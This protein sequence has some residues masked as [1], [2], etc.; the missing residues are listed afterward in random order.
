RRGG[1]FSFGGAADIVV[2]AGIGALGAAAG[3]WLRRPGGRLPPEIKAGA[4]RTR[5]SQGPASSR[6]GRSR[7]LR[8]RLSPQLR[9][10]TVAPALQKYLRRKARHLR[11]K[12][13]LK[14][15]HP[16]DIA[17]VDRAFQD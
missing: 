5:P 9:W 11:G 16:E 17:V 2:V 6:R 8:A 7:S 4:K 14:I 12:S 15:V 1:D 3:G 10:L 13:F